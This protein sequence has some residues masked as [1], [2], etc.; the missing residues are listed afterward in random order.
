[1][2]QD[3]DIERLV[4]IALLG[5]KEIT[6]LRHRDFRVSYKSGNVP[7]TA[8]DVNCEQVIVKELYSSFSDIPIV[9]EERTA[10]T[11]FDSREIF[12][13]VDPLDGTKEFLK[14]S[15][16]FTVN[17][18]LV[19][20]GAPTIGI[21]YAPALDTVWIG[22]AGRGASEIKIE[23]GRVSSRRG[24]R[25]RPRPTQ[26]TALVS[27]S[28]SSPETEA[29]LGQLGEG[30]SEARGSSIKF[31]LIANGSADVYPR[32]GRTMEWDTAAGEAILREAGGTVTTLSGTKLGY[33]KCGLQNKT[34]FENPPF[35][36]VGDQCDD[37]FLST[38][39]QACCGVT[40]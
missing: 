28:H 19:E 39:S 21:I 37:R 23:A 3:H 8:A 32:L 22:L 40:N 5:G 31:C 14:G 30:E 9:S 4:E 24:I 26:F 16:D 35:I 34:D 6:S 33:G 27:R 13:L 15:S 17:I 36:A 20:K 25:T 10:P 7:V 2:Q 29:W 38:A 18:A 11:S 1:M 12:F